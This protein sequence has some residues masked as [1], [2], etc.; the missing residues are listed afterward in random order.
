MQRQEIRTTAILIAVIALLAAACGGPPQPGGGDLEGE[1]SPSRTVEIEATDALTFEP[2]TIEVAQGATITFVI[3]NPGT[4]DHEFVVGTPAEHGMM[5]GGGHD[6]DGGS[7]DHVMPG[8]MDGATIPAGERVELT[9]RFEEP[10]TLE[11]ACHLDGHY[12]AGMR[13]VIIVT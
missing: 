7:T 8:G 9:M 13:G 10:A 2:E 12:E 4:V 5:A 6:M 3:R 11:I 1:R